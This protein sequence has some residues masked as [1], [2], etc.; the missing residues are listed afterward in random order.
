MEKSIGLLLLLLCLLTAC[1]SPRSNETSEQWKREIRETEQ[2]F[3]KLALAAGIEK[4]F[5]TYAA[6]EAVLM[7]NDSLILGKPQI[8]K[9]YK[10]QT[11]KGLSWSPE[12]IEVSASGDLGY[13]YGYYH[14]I[15]VD[16]TGHTTDQK[17]VFH[18]VWKRQEDG[19][20]RFVWD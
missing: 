6:E 19:T 10:G 18:T 1:G 12:F 15:S 11:S 5:L 16:S 2:A 8:A 20:W 13:T 7:R 14:F 4:A 3:A 17:G 9:H